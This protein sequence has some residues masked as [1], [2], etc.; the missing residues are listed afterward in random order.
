MM[1]LRV[2]KFQHQLGSSSAAT[3]AGESYTLK[4]L[5]LSK[6][7]E[8]HRPGECFNHNYPLVSSPDARIIL[9]M[10]D[11]LHTGFSGGRQPP[12]KRFFIKSNDLYIGF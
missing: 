12:E 11:H 8:S 10:R 1:G 7:P 4:N 6:A 2:Q 3:S 9:A 5:V